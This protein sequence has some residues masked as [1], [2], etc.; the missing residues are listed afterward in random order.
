MEKNNL[1]EH[2]FEQ[3]IEQAYW[4]FDGRR[5][6][7]NNRPPES[8]RDAFKQICRGLVNTAVDILENIDEKT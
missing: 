4:E 1:T 6:G 5:N 3:L 8:E 2:S 7:S